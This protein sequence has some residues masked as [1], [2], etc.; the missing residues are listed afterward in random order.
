MKQ[1]SFSV[2]FY[3]RRKHLNK[4]GETVIYARITINGQR[5]DVSTKR[6][7]I[8]RFWDEQ[9]GIAKN[10]NN[11]LGEL[12]EYLEQI[13][14]KIYGIQKKLNDSEVELS[15]QIIKD[16]Y[17]GNRKQKRFLLS[18]Y[19]EHNDRMKDLIGKDFALATNKRHITT[20]NH[21]QDFINYKFKGK[22]VPLKQVDYAF[23]KDFEFHMKTA[24]NCQHNTCVKNIK[25]LGKI[26][27]IAMANEWIQKDPFTKIKLRSTKVPKIYLEEDELE[28][29]IYT[30]IPNKRLD[31]V[32]DI[33]VFCCFTGLAFIDIKN[34]NENDIITGID[35]NYWIKKQ[36]IKTKQ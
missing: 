23:I 8:P 32:R 26:I 27:R 20:L 9:R 11:L 7:I 17:L 15:P 31:Q 34:L 13:R 29:L 12:N 19:M 10:N 18:T 21:I 22:D 36:R 33:F 2:S 28:K 30:E 3:I 14:Y 4:Y 16:E 1:V 35:S 6:F 5:A 25:N 24:K